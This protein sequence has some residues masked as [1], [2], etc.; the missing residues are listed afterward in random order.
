MHAAPWLASGR[1][2]CS[3]PQVSVCSFRGAGLG[4]QEPFSTVVPTNCLESRPPELLSLDLPAAVE[5]T[6]AA[7]TRLCSPGRRRSSEAVIFGKGA[8]L[9]SFHPDG[10]NAKTTSIITFNSSKNYCLLLHMEIVPYNHGSSCLK[11][12]PQPGETRGPPSPS[13]RCGNRPTYQSPCRYQ[14]L[15]AVAKKL[16][17]PHIWEVEPSPRREKSRGKAVVVIMHTCGSSPVIS[18]AAEFVFVLTLG[19]GSALGC[20]NSQHLR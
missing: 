13:G 14:A 15:Q 8:H 18:L 5:F 7:C 12:G 4:R 19:C 16:A 9:L 6:G 10:G 17:E 11:A 1:K 20:G 3:E 2:H